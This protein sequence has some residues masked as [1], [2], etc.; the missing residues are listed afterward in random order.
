MKKKIFILVPIF[1]VIVVSVILYINYKKRI[2]DIYGYALIEPVDTFP[3]QQYQRDLRLMELHKNGKDITIAQYNDNE[4]EIVDDFSFNFVKDHYLFYAIIYHNSSDKEDRYSK[5]YRF[6][7]NKPMSKPEELFSGKGYS[8]DTCFGDFYAF[9]YVNRN[10]YY[11][12][13]LFT[14]HFVHYHDGKYDLMS[15]EEFDSSYGSYFDDIKNTS[16]SYPLYINGDLYEVKG[17]IEPETD[18]AYK[19]GVEFYRNKENERLSQ[20]LY[21][22]NKDIVIRA[23]RY[24]K[25]SNETH[26]KDIYYKYDNGIIKEVKLNNDFYV[27]FYYIP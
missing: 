14:D 3:K 7:L 21:T 11:F 20:F 18:I 19:N 5:A 22:L 2:N 6:D 27:G 17:A 9:M 15:F 25:T 24:Y 8:D 16:E 13:C 26:V 12:N 1:I 10:D 4:N 23:G